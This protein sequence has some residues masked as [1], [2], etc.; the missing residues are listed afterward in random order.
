MRLATL[1]VLSALHFACTHTYSGYAVDGSLSCAERVFSEMGYPVV[2]IDSTRFGVSLSRSSL[3]PL[4][5]RDP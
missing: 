4:A 3:A 1:I 5:G 2:W